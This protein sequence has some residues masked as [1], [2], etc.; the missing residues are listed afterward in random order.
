MTPVLGQI[1]G[2]ELLV[3]IGAVALLFGG[4]QLPR[5]A[6]SVGGAKQ[7]FEQGLRDGAPDHEPSPGDSATGRSR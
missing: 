1:I 7:Q 3:V 4:A 2:W 5:L 6:R